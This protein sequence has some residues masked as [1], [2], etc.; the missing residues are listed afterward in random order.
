[1]SRTRVNI[2]DSH[3][4]PPP[5]A[6]W[7]PSIPVRVARARSQRSLTLK[8][9]T[10]SSPLQRQPLPRFVSPPPSISRLRKIVH[11]SVL[12]LGHPKHSFIHRAIG[13]EVNFTVG[14]GLESGLF[15]PGANSSP[16]RGILM[17]Q[18]VPPT[19]S[20]GAVWVTQC[21]RL[22]NEMKG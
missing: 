9:R 16:F 21:L 6:A 22:L 15:D 12:T 2:P 19:S 14:H 17:K 11:R 7:P 3:G 8:L 10:P 20:R 4:L 13:G 1:M 18:R 5:I